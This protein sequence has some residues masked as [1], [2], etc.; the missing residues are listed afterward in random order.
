MGR[1]PCV[2][3]CHFLSTHTLFSFFPFPFFV[4]AVFSGQSRW[5]VNT[6][7]PIKMKSTG[8]VIGYFNR[9]R[10]D[11][12]VQYVSF[13]SSVESIEGTKIEPATPAELEAIKE[14]QRAR[15]RRG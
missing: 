14:R 7:Q 12:M 9:Q 10:E 1:H 15:G 13:S 3:V 11:G 5:I 2:F 6:L 4:G 8:R